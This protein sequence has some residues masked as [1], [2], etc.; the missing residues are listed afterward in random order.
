MG[1]TTGTKRAQKMKIKLILL[2]ITI[3]FLSCTS[4]IKNIDKVR[5]IRSKKGYYVSDGV[6]TGLSQCYIYSY[7]KP[8]GR[9]LHYITFYRTDCISLIQ[10]G[11]SDY[12]N[13]GQLMLNAINK[14]GRSR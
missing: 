5:Q 4:P 9:S 11:N 12:S 1:K 2:T 7:M 6:S 14:Y 8:K 10:S 3:L 13:H